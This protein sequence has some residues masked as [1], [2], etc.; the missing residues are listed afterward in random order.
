MWNGF[1]IKTQLIVFMTIIVIVVEASTLFFILNVQKK[2]NQQNAITQTNAITQS[3]NNDLL[4][5]ILNPNADV[6]SDITFRLSAFK[7]IRG[8]IL[9]D[10]NKKAIFQYGDTKE[11]TKKQL[12]IFEEETIF[13]DE[14]LFV[15]KDITADNYTLGFELI[16]VDL[17]SFKQKEEQITYTILIIFPFALLFGF[18]I[19]LFLSKNYTRPFIELLDAMRKSD[20]TNNK[21]TA[22]ST[23]ANNEIKELYD[24]FN[25]QMKQIEKSS[26]ELK[27]QANHDQLTNIY[28]RFFMKEELLNALKND[29]PNIKGY[30]YLL[31]NLDQFKLVNDSAG[32]Q[33]GDELLKMIVTHYQAILPKGTP[34]GRI[35]GDT[36]SVLL[37]DSNEKFGKKF[38]EESL[39]RLHDF[40]FSYKGETFS[41]SA[42]ISLVFFKPFEFTLKELLKASTTSLY[43]AKQKGRGKSQIFDPSDEIAKRV[44]MEIDTAKLI[45]EAL[46][47]GP[48]RFE[49]FAQDIVPLQY[50]TD[51]IS[52]EIL[53]R[54]W[55]KDNNF[56][57]PDSFLPTAERYQLMA[58]IDMHVLWTYLE[59]V[60]KNKNHI[61]KLHSAH[62]NLAG[63]SLNNPDFQAKVKKAIEH[64]DFPWDKLELEI[65]ESS[66]I[67]NFNMANEFI[68]WL[69]KQNIG[70]ALDDFGTGMASFEYL[71]SLPFDVV[72]IDGSFVKD[73]H[74]DPID[75]AVIKYIQ[76]IAQLKGQETVAEYV[77]TKEDVEELK[78]IGVTYG[79]GYFLG[80]PRAL[81][82]W[83]D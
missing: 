57:P 74:T 72:K 75:K 39:K 5:F 62:I 83:L 2:E 61:E 27:F 52:Y 58:D 71:K 38:L 18:L 4:N 3:L 48:A 19:S 37:K 60:T 42:C 49:L 59:T 73:M 56:I 41:V 16:D 28:N 51:K 7:E 45:K 69:K 21:I 70:L 14:H 25:L 82:S 23:N 63:S 80:K 66:A 9:Y 22:V 54:M 10:E 43:T 67:G 47:D 77:E 53:I 68:I 76:E 64:F 32:Y 20:P 46:A 33:A 55:D 65:T 31:I 40:R 17:S 44:S 35:D 1:R 36:F 26:K 13:I 6:L 79:Q 11:L 50:D 12:S 81:S 15:K 78:A 34:F 8:V 29:S 30:N 24:G